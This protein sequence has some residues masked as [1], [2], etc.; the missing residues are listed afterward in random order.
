LVNWVR[1][2]GNG[3]KIMAGIEIKLHI[4]EILRTDHN[5]GN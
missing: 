5:G 4:K 3:C 1:V 2:N